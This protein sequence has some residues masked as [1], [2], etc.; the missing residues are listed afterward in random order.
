MDG[1]VY[2]LRDVCGMLFALLGLP[3]F[4]IMSYTTAGPS[5]SPQDFSGMNITDEDPI[6]R[7]SPDHTMVSKPSNNGGY[8]A[9]TKTDVP[10]IVSRST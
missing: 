6:R 3:Y 9:P 10:L 8:H 5:T 2:I 1:K 4:L 7:A